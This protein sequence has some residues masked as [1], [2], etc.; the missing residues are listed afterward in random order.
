TAGSVTGTPV[1]NVLKEWREAR[2][3]TSEDMAATL[4]MSLDDYERLERDPRRMTVAAME[5][6]AAQMDAHFV[7]WFQPTTGARFSEYVW[8]Q[9][10]E[11]FWRDSRVMAAPLERRPL[12]LAVLARDEMNKRDIRRRLGWAHDKRVRL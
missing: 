10:F 3:K 8:K 1:T 2:D 9:L 12:K 5:A 6:L 4:S 7:Y 11:I